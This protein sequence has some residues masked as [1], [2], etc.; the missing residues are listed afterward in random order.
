MLFPTYRAAE[1]CFRYMMRFSNQDLSSTI[2]IVRFVVQG[3]IKSLQ[4]NRGDVVMEVDA[5]IFS[6]DLWKLAKSFWQNA[7]MGVSSRYASRILELIQEG[8]SLS[9][10][11]SDSRANLV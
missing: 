3:S 4:E 1:E 11:P 7:G 5:V 8:N 10:Q 2:S 9:Q 6:P